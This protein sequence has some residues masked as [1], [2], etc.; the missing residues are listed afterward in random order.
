[1]PLFSTVPSSVGDAQDIHKDLTTFTAHL[2]ELRKIGETA[3]P[4]P[5]KRAALFKRLTGGESLKGMDPLI[6]RR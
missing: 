1:M 5:K 4:D 2:L 6:V 3:G